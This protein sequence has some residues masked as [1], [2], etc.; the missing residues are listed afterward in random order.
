MAS[1]LRVEARS[2]NMAKRKLK[3]VTRLTR[4]DAAGLVEALVEGLKDGILKVQKSGETLTLEVP[5]V[6][7][8]GI[9]A[10][11]SDERA[12]F[13]IDVSWRTNRAENPDTLPGGAVGCVCSGEEDAR[14]REALANAA[15][16]LDVSAKK[17]AGTMKKV[18]AAKK[19]TAAG[20]KSKKSVANPRATNKKNST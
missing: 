16:Q 6:V 8:F 19:E 4:E 15:R 11:I 10:T 20:A 7:D 12:E 18:A 14:V 5:R 13:A 2:G 3:F 1:S 17:A 9:E